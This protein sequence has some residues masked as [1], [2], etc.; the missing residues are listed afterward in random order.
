M[1][2]LKVVAGA[3]GKAGAVTR[4]GVGAA[5]V[6]Y[7]G[8]HLAEEAE[9]QVEAGAE[10]AEEDTCKA[11]ERAVCTVNRAI[12]AGRAMRNLRP[13]HRS[14]EM[15]WQRTRRCKGIACYAIR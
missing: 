6:T 14:V 4:Q 13:I 11:V 8:R 5:E 7:T 2:L 15:S 9:A 10:E 1:P 12:I 3:M